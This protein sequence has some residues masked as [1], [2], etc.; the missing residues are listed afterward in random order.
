MTGPQLSLGYWQDKQKTQNAF[1]PA[2][3][4]QRI[5][6]RTGDRVRR[7]GPG[8]PL[9]YLG[10]LDN[11]I[12]VLGHRVE[13]G[14]VEAVIRETSGVAGVVAVGWP[15]TGSGADAIE[16]FLETNQL[17]MQELLDKLKTRLPAYMLP[18]SIHLMKRFP[19]NASGKY[20][21]RALQA[22]L[23]TGLFV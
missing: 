1:V 13:L 6:Y 4:E 3:D 5:Y 15:R 2:T 20:D 19:L 17:D 21:R 8:R 11:Q 16:V 22:M 12:K 18:R 10:R 23:E 9:V 14:E 7:A